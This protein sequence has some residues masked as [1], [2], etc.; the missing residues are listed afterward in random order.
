MLAQQQQP[1]LLLL[2]L[3]QPLQLKQLLLSL[4]AAL[5]AAGLLP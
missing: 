3:Q 1:L 5:L 4:P 2:V